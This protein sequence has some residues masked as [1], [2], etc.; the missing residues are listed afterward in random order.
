MGSTAKEEQLPLE[1]G[2]EKDLNLKALYKE[3]L[4]FIEKKVLPLC[5]LMLSSF[6]SSGG[7]HCLLTDA[8]WPC[9]VD[10]LVSF[11]PW[12]FSSAHPPT[13]HQHYLW[14]LEFLRDF[15]GLYFKLYLEGLDGPKGD[16][17]GSTE[18]GSLERIAQCVQ[19]LRR[20]TSYLEFMRR[21]QLH[22]YFQWRYVYH[23]RVI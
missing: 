1:E 3:L 11:C 21:W 19:G 8:V 5:R 10:S 18:E 13:F 4:D 22:V 14:T 7:G 17:S 9:L 23:H 16:L 6:S 20:S 2:K 15:E 12:I